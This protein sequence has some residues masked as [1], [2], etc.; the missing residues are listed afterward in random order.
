MCSFCVL[1]MSSP[2]ANKSVAAP[3]LHGSSYTFIRQY[4][5]KHTTDMER[6]GMEVRTAH[7][8]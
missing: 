3:C 8:M 4:S 1:A 6:S 5:A 7:N 2:L